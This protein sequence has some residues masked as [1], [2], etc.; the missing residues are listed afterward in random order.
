[1]SHS[2]SS[3]EILVSSSEHW[4]CTFLILGER[5][6]GDVFGDHNQRAFSECL[7]FTPG[8]CDCLTKTR[9]MKLDE[10]HSRQRGGDDHV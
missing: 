10:A 6:S 1:M 7:A 9:V 2:S 5:A 3:L 8:R 4:P